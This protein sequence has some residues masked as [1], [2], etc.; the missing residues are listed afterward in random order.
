MDFLTVVQVVRRQWRV[1]VPLVVLSLVLAYLAA[2]SVPVT[3]Q[4]HGVVLLEPPLPEATEG[5]GNPAADNRLLSIGGSLN[6]VGDI[7]AKVVNDESTHAAVREAGGGEYTVGA[8]QAG[9]PLLDIQA[10]SKDS[11]VALATIGLVGEAITS[12]LENQQAASGA[13]TDSL[14]VARPL[15]SSRTTTALYGGRTRT[16]AAVTLLGIAGSISL[17]F[18]LDSVAIRRRQAVARASAADEAS[19]PTTSDP[20]PAEPSGS[21]EAPPLRPVEHPSGWGTAR[22]RPGSRRPRAGTR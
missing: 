9:A 10:T 5:E 17:A 22:A 3:H 6:V 19:E 2:S 18:L 7:I 15:T 14:I 1:V 20:P 16:L 8:Q 21:S 11:A 4:A 12:E 13:S